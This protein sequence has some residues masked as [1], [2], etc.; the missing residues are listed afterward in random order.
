MTAPQNLTERERDKFRKLLEVAN[1]T[2]YEGEKDAALA[3]ATRLARSRGMSLHE[4]AGMADTS[5]DHKP[6]T[7]ERQQARK[8]DTERSFGDTIRTPASR[9]K[10][11]S[12][13]ERV[14][15]EKRHYDQAMEDAVRRGLRVDE[16]R[17]VSKKPLKAR[18]AGSGSWRSK[19]DFIRVLLKET[20][21]SV[22]EIAST[23][24][25]SVN[26]VFKEKLLMRQASGT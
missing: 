2:T 20:R 23:A 19:P 21:M 7:R 14:A 6:T 8:R 15:A 22:S 18:R 5:N 1:S 17:P 24:G 10:Y 3:A 11:R 4:A 25:V 16:D 12:E 26:E 13:G 9:E